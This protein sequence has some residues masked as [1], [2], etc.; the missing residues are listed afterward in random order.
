MRDAR[1][2]PRRL[3]SQIKPLLA[4]SDNKRSWGFLV[5][6]A[7]SVGLPVFVGAALDHF[8]SAVL[9]SMGGLVILYMQQTGV[10]RRMMTLAVC[11]FGFATSFALGV[12]TS[13]NPYL[14]ALTLALT[15]F[16]VT[17]VCRLFSVPPPGSFFFIL[18]AC[19]ARTLP[20][21]LLLAAERTGILI[22][23]CIGA[24]LVALIYSLVQQ[25][26]RDPRTASPVAAGDR[27]VAAIILESAVISVF[28][29]GGYLAALLIQLDNPYWVPVSTA[30]IMQGATF[31]A[32]WHR[33]VHRIFGTFVG[34]AL[35]WA[36]FSLSPDPWTLAVLVMLLSFLIE[37]LVT[38][39]YGLAVIFMTP[40]TVIFADSAYA[41]ADTDRLIMARMI[42]IVI[43]SVIGYV[44]GWVIHHPRLFSYLEQRMLNR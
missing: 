8:S 30:A 5:A 20:F 18:V 12:L 27:R 34:M 22:F 28:I 43:G 38:R 10:A 31:R 42:D 19:I 44:G 41:A 36:I 2:S 16:M 32:V 14:S 21:D 29:G 3:W 40:L 11:S 26:F 9:A 25:L 7:I 33:N 24:C 17:L 37:A 23:G 1:P 39:N 6:A 13:F 35:A 4:F 15:A